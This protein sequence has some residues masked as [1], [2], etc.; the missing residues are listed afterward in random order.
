MTALQ[1]VQ[2]LIRRHRL[3]DWIFTL[4]SHPTGAGWRQLHRTAEQRIRQLPASLQPDPPPGAAVV[5]HSLLAFGPGDLDR[6]RPGPGHV[7]SISSRLTPPGGRRRR[8]LALM[9]LH[10]DEYI[11]DDRLADAVSEIAEGR[12]AW[13]V[14][15]DRHHH[16]YGSFL[17]GEG[18]WRRWNLRFLLPLA[19]ADAHY[20]GRSLVWGAN[21]LRLNAGTTFQ[22]KMPVTVDARP[23]EVPGPAARAAMQLA[24]RHSWQLRK[25]GA[26]MMRHLHEVARLSAAIRGQCL[27]LG[28]PPPEDATDEQLFA[29]GFL[30]DLVEDTNSDYDDVAGAAGEQVADWVAVLTADKRLRFADRRAQYRRQLRAACGPARIVKLADLL[31]N[32]RGL[33]GHEGRPWIADYIVRVEE[34]LELIREGLD[35]TT[36]FAEARDLIARWR[37]EAGG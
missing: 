18:D 37:A 5:G 21:L 31:S 3:Q 24:Q 16:V 32:L 33:T 29:C 6:F 22:M 11:A 7:V 28:A 13:L 9:D 17:L 26:A 2:E 30:H 35:G 27:A 19:L 15:T 4:V 12:E 20:I 1:V 34:E 23:V 10:P 25:N 8:H 14:R 36:A